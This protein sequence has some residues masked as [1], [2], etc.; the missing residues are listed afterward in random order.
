MPTD[1]A[2]SSRLAAAAVAAI[3]DRAKPAEHLRPAG[4]Q[5]TVGTDD[6]I[7]TNNFAGTISRRC[8]ALRGVWHAPKNG[9]VR[10]HKKAADQLRAPGRRGKGSDCRRA[11]SN[12]KAATPP[13]SHV[14][15]PASRFRRPS[16]GTLSNHAF[17]AAF[18][19]NVEWNPLGAT[20]ALVGTRGSV[21]ELVPS[22]NRLGF[23]WGGHYHH[24]KD[25]M[26]FE[27]AKLMTRPELDAAVRS[28]S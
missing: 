8:P 14:R 24:R 26:H 4:L 15:K 20:P 12:G 10:W 25:G 6:I 19:I 21:R 23:F 28:L 13:A 11:F 1:P 17:G 27:V 5:G 16:N 2:F 9:A 7:I 18:D 3:A 22:A